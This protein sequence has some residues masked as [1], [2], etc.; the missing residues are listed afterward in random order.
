MLSLLNFFSCRVLIVC[1]SVLILLFMV[2]VNC[3]YWLSFNL[4]FN[5]SLSLFSFVVDSSMYC[6]LAMMIAF[7]RWS[8]ARLRIL[9]TCLFKC[10]SWVHEARWNFKWS[11]LG[12][13]LLFLYV[14]S[15]SLCEV[16]RQMM[17]DVLPISSFRRAA[18]L[19]I[20]ADSEWT[21]AVWFSWFVLSKDMVA[22]CPTLHWVIWIRFARETVRGIYMLILNST[23][24]P[25]ELPHQTLCCVWELVW[26][27]ETFTF[28]VSV[29]LQ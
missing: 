17:L 1:L 22:P 29:L 5:C 19:G 7:W 12:V 23:W 4:S 9:S 14:L 24:N 16:Y 2:S 20:I 11:P 21:S 10:W 13:V 25:C 27:E 3:L 26:N 28:L 18:V 6:V 8:E 15:R